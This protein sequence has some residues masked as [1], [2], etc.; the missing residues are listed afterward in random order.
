MGS[1]VRIETISEC[2]CILYFGEDINEGISNQ[3]NQASIAL[4]KA[5]G[6]VLIDLIPSYTSILVHFDLTKTD[7]YDIK[8]R[9]KTT[10]K[11][12]SQIKGLRSKHNIID[13]PVYYGPET[14]LDLNEVSKMCD[15]SPSEIIKRH[16]QK[17]YRVYAIGFSPGFAYLGS[18]DKE[19]VV[20]RKA[21]P[22]LKV[23]QGSVGL[24]D[25]QT[26][27]YPSTSP[28]GWQIIGRTPNKMVDWQ[29]SSP[30]K[31][32]VGDQIRFCPI[33]RREFETL[34]GIL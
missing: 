34:G 13:V 7:R 20:P 1:R 23:P 8:Q 28:G 17:E 15:L 31:I 6:P 3:V 29:N 32:K 24:A 25:N 11:Q 19:I 10:L 12:E 9:I 26:A 2:C 22:R 16:S 30:T 18:L 21:T 14:A 5:L 33:T 4:T 27:I